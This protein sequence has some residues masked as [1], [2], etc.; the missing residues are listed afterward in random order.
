MKCS[1]IGCERALSSS[2]WQPLAF[3][4]GASVFWSVSVACFAAKLEC[5]VNVLLI[6]AWI[7]FCI[8]VFYFEP[9]EIETQ[10]KIGS[11]IEKA[12][13]VTG[14]AYY[15]PELLHGFTHAAPSSDHYGNLCWVQ[16]NWFALASWRRTPHPLFFTPTSR[17]LLCYMHLLF[18]NTIPGANL[19][20]ELE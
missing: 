6:F 15:K 18:S 5:S 20:N 10:L 11:Q 19:Y 3:M 4:P 2:I 13:Q 17:I 9:E 14:R 16:M 8:F 7:N 1:R 12:G